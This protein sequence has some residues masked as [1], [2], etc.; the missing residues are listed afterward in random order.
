MSYPWTRAGKNGRKNNAITKPVFHGREIP[1]KSDGSEEDIELELERAKKTIQA[2]EVTLKERDCEIKRL[3]TK[4]D[5]NTSF[6]QKTVM[7]LIPLKGA[8]PA[9]PALSPGV[10]DYLAKKKVREEEE[11][12]RKGKL[13]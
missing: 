3:L 2:L 12:K 9:T 5:E 1:I 11:A 7:E 13:P 10:A 8:T 6:L 4:L